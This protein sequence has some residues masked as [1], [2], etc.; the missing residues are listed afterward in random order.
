MRESSIQVSKE[1]LKSYISIF[2]QNQKKI[3]EEFI[4][5]KI[6]RSGSFNNVV[7]LFSKFETGKAKLQ[8]QRNN[9]EEAK[10]TFIQALAKYDG[11]AI[12]TLKEMGTINEELRGLFF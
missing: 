10:Q 6:L 5:E 9:L 12:E 2:E 11:Q 4:Q 3:Y 1:R 7:S 8:V